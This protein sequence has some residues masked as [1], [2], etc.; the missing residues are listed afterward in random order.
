MDLALLQ[1]LVAVVEEGS[2]SGAGQ[3]LLRTQPAISLALQRLE[4]DLGEK[5]VDRSSKNLVLTDAGRVVLEYARRF[6]GL[7]QELRNALVELRDKQ[8]GKLTI[9]ANESTALYLLVHI[10]AYRK[11]YPGVKVE[12]RRSLSSRIP[13][14]VLNGSLDLGAVSYAPRDPSLVAKEIYNDRLTFIV[15]PKHRFAGREKLSISELGMETFIAHNVVSPYRQQV[16]DTFRRLKVPLKM[17]IEMPTIETIR[18]LVQLNMGVAFLPKMCVEQ[19]IA[20]GVLKEVPVEE[21][22]MER[23]IRLEYAAKRRLSHA[24]QA[25]LEVVGRGE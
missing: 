13:E 12:I 25:F 10:E 18:K 17:E 7:E 15:S 2:F 14:A 23:K 19:E 24:A 20:A 3:K 11:L 6:D 5:L 21:M 8:A 1:T 16:I 9:G 22:Q 4:A